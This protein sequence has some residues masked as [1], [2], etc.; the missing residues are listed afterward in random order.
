M[1]TE[2]NPVQSNYSGQGFTGYATAIQA[3]GVKYVIV[4]DSEEQL[5][6]AY[7][8]ATHLF[9][10]SEKSTSMVHVLHIRKP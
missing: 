4:A 8:H 9:D 2:T 5:A 6:K 3:P 10:Y 7:R 1:I